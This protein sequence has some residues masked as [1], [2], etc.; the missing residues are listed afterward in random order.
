MFKLFSSQLV[1]SAGLIAFSIG[2]TEIGHAETGVESYQRQC[3]RCHGA[4]GAGTENAPEPLIGDKSVAELAKVIAATMPQDAPGTCTG[5]DAARV[6][7]FIHEDFY[8]PVA[9]ARRRPARVEYSRLTVRQYRNAVADLIAS[10]RP[11]PP[12]LGD[13]PGLLGRYLQVRDG[14][15][16][17][18]SFA[19]TD[20]GIDFDF[21]DAS[22]NPEKINAEEFAMWWHGAVFAPDT[23]E[24]EFIIET[25]NGIRLWVNGQQVINDWSDHP[26]ST[27]TSA[28]VALTAGQTYPVVLEYYQNT[29]GAQAHLLWQTPGSGSYVAIPKAQ[30]SPLTY[31]YRQSTDGGTTWSPTPVTGAQATV[32]EQGETQVQYRATDAAGNVSGWGPASGT[33][34]ATVRLDRTGAGG[35]SG[36]ELVSNGSFESPALGSGFQTGSAGQGYGAWSITSGTVELYATTGGWN[37]AAGSQSVDMDG[38]PGPGAI[39]QTITTTPGTVYRISFALSG[40]PGGTQ[41]V[42]ELQVGWGGSALRTVRFDTTGRSTTAMGWTTVTL[43]AT[44]TSTNTALTF[45]SLSSGGNNGPAIDNVSVVPQSGPTVSGGSLSWLNQASTTITGADATDAHSGVSGYEYRTSTDGGS[46]WGSATAGAADKISIAVTVLVRMSVRIR[47]IIS[48][49]IGGRLSC[50]GSVPGIVYVLRRVG[51]VADR[52]LAAFP[53]PGRVVG[54]EWRPTV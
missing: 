46:T 39:S 28:G 2:W 19:R 53:N 50:G 44:A 26:L 27:V 16:D 4:A 52:P 3:A 42:K 40:N 12:Q 10:F 13:E 29:G 20:P 32:T 31:E 15:M 7:A 47:P 48:I 17:D 18:H 41:G 45:Q 9:Q 49:W 8:S 36:S 25:Q 34:G 24:Y 23:G 43:E 21:G 35:N 14:P 11:R 6:A 37:A 33:A 38:S 5:E 51:P 22:P 54:T 1:L 30:L